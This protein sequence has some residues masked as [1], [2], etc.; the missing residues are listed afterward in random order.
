MAEY[1]HLKVTKEIVE[2]GID[3]SLLSKIGVRFKPCSKSEE[4]KRSHK[5]TEPLCFICPGHILYPYD[6]GDCRGQTSCFRLP[7]EFK[8]FIRIG[9]KN[10]Q[11]SE[12]YIE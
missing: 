7:V 1:Y 10:Q 4:W 11:L 2:K 6:D 8:P 12:D 3:F 9:M 5:E